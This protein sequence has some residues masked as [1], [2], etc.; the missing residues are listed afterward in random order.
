[1]TATIAHVN[2][3]CPCEGGKPYQNNN[4]NKRNNNSK[5]CCFSFDELLRF[6]LP[7]LPRPPIPEPKPQTNTRSQITTHV[8]WFC[9]FLLKDGLPGDLPG[10]LHSH[11]LDDCP[12]AR[13][14]WGVE[15]GLRFS[16]GLFPRFGLRNWFS[17]SWKKSPLCVSWVCFLFF[18]VWGGFFFF[19]R[20]K[21]S[22]GNALIGFK[23]DFPSEFAAWVKLVNLARH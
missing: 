5:L 3:V 9:F 6:W 11:F 4:N 19:V 21:L 13:A 8:L 14:G 22:S 12:S 2:E 1:M 18:F 20:G 15:I 7:G 23:R 17:L 10:L 16:P